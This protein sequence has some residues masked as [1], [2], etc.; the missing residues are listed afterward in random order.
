V[1]TDQRGQAQLALASAGLP[2]NSGGGFE[3]LQ[4]DQGFGTSQFVETA[5]YQ[6]A[7]ETELARTIGNLR[8]VLEARVHLA[9]PKASAFTRQKESAS[10]SV[11][12]QLRSGSVLEAGQVNAI[13]HLVSGS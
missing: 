10:A 5:R 3:S 4:G 11:V 2:S 7:L 9:M 13:V 12:L 1:P 8:P 6:H